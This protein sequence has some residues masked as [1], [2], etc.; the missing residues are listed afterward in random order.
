V[1]PDRAP[2][3]QPDQ[4]ELGRGA[5]GELVLQRYPDLTVHLLRRFRLRGLGRFR[6]RTTTGLFFFDRRAASFRLW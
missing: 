3:V 6:V 4:C 5:A 2:D 1:E